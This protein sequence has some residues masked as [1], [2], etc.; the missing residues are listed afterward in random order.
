M[1]E[2]VF[3]V[4]KVAKQVIAREAELNRGTR[5]FRTEM[6][7]GASGIPHV[8]S[9][10]DGV[11]SYVVNLGLKNLGVSSELIAFMDDL[12]G[13]RKVPIGFPAELETQ[14]GKPVANILDPFGCHSSFGQHTSALILEAFE[15]LGVQFTLKRAS[16][17]YPKGTL[18]K[19]VTDILNDWR[20]V[21]KIIMDMT[22]QDKYM[23]QLPF[24]PFC[25]KCGRVYTTV[26]TAFDGEKIKYSCTGEF[27]GKGSRGQELTIKGCGWSGEAG[28]REG[29]LAWKVDFAAR[30][31]ALRINY[32]AYGKDIMDS[33]KVNDEICRTVL[34]W[35][36]PLH[37]MY[38]LFTERG[39]KK[40]SKSVG[41]VFTPQIWLKYASPESMRLLFL[42]KLG[43]T[44]VVDID[45]IPAYVEELDKITKVYFGDIKIANEREL[46]HI[47]RLY[48]YVHFLRPPPSK[49]LMVPYSVLISLLK[50]V[51]EVDVVKTILTKTGHLPKTMSK[52]EEASI[53]ERINQAKAWVTDAGLLKT[54]EVKLTETQKKVVSKLV[55]ELKKEWDEKALESRLYSL[56]REFEMEPKELFRT[57]YMILLGSPV[58]PRLAMLILAIGK[59]NVASRLCAHL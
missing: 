16:E 33:V 40:I 5:T 14:I 37:S 27:I 45:A 3:W 21:G 36:P 8:G 43:K 42:K 32:E 28:I 53:I 29:K 2:D 23:K 48:E 24:M 34:K 35:E 7:L 18:D 17:E 50:I 58:G 1:P 6:G 38:E 26:A 54:T 20:R 41:N 30:W 4:D 51:P 57:I 46:A 25:E 52:T 55:K 11:R 39:G 49:P 47:R 12:D 9:V 19:E 15:K 56:A 59:E 10:G 44:R 13:L 22:G 31:R